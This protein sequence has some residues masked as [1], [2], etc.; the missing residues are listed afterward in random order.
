MASIGSTTSI[1]S[2]NSIVGKSNTLTT[3]SV[4]YVGKTSSTT[5]N[6]IRNS[7]MNTVKISSATI[8]NT[9]STTIRY[10]NSSATSKVISSS[11]VRTNSSATSK[12]SNL[13]TNKINNTSS[14]TSAIVTSNVSK[15][16][17][18]GNTTV[19]SGHTNIS[20]SDSNTSEFDYS[21]ISKVSK[22]AI[23]MF[24]GFKLGGLTSSRLYDVYSNMEKMAGTETADLLFSQ[25]VAGCCYDRLAFNVFT[26]L[27]SSS[28]DLL[29][30]YGMNENQADEV[31]DAI[32]EQHDYANTKND[33]VDMAHMFCTLSVY[34]GG[35]IAFVSDIA[36]IE[37]GNA[38]SSEVTMGF[39]GDIFGIDLD[40]KVHDYSFTPSMNNDDYMADLDA[41][42]ISGAW[43]DSSESLI[44]VI[45]EYY[46]KIE[47]D[48]INRAEVFIENMGGKEK[49]DKLYSDAV[50]VKGENDASIMFKKAIDNRQQELKEDIGYAPN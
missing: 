15:T 34:L 22:F 49:F 10:G 3:S 9:G 25:M 42:N 19:K 38:Y 8:R 40:L 5:A 29:M 41:V 32:R 1:Y 36:E 7:N 17:V 39:G 44:D 50:L 24:D 6:L 33:R 45:L 47:S 14:S 13:L 11:T 43:Y 20:L 26:G 31:I 30:T 23:A 4:C 46:S 18:V 37:S 2:M 28:K 48:K 16:P 21:S 27:D 35:S 12:D